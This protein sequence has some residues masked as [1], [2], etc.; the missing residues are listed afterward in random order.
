MN[1][2]P[3]LNSSK[4]LRDLVVESKCRKGKA[5]GTDERGAY[6]YALHLADECYARLFSR[7]GDG[8]GRSGADITGWLEFKHYRNGDMVAQLVFHTWH[9]NDGPGDQF[10]VADI[11]NCATAEEVVVALKKMEMP[12]GKAALG[13]ERMVNGLVQ[14]LVGDGLV[15]AAPAPDDDNTLPLVDAQGVE[16]TRNIV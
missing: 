16:L 5:H 1:I 7:G 2:T 3:L 14:Q 9:E 13:S 12:D 15:E 8:I 10:F 11:L 4:L 6:W